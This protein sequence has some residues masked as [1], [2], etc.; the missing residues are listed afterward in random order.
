MRATIN[1]YKINAT[2]TN[3]NLNAKETNKIL[4][5]TKSVA[6]VCGNGTVAFDYAYGTD[7]TET[8]YQESLVDPNLYLAQYSNDL[9]D[10]SFGDIFYDANNSDN[11]LKKDTVDDFGTVVREIYYVKTKLNARPA[12][13]V[14]WSTSDNR[15]V[16]LIG[17]KFSNFEAEAYVL[18]NTSTTI[19]LSDGGK[20]SLYI[21]GNEINSS[22]TLEYS[23]D[24]SP[25]YVNK[26]PVI[27]ESRWLQNQKD[28]Q[29]LANFI[30]TKA[31]N[32]RHAYS[33][34]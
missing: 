22:G 7:M 2:D 12:F 9:L 19:P 6:I 17:Q 20:A 24:D 23:T 8:K 11:T 16:N 4:A 14:R 21:F 13:P 31:I 34:F 29:N 1:G 33:R 3:S 32:K 18:N 27:F 30:K 28:V 26:E 5:P 15:S 10:M 25:E